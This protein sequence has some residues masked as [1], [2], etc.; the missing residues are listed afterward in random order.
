MIWRYRQRTKRAQ[1]MRTSSVRVHGSRWMRPCP[2]E[3]LCSAELACVC[4]RH[5]IRSMRSRCCNRIATSFLKFCRSIPSR[6]EESPPWRVKWG[7]VDTSVLWRCVID[8]IAQGEGRI[9]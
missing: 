7:A 4:N 2:W 5:V 6:A 3:P 1:A 8:R 9:L